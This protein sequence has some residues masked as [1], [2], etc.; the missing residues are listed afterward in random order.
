VYGVTY[1][2]SYE[3]STGNYL[4]VLNSLNG[5]TVHETI[6]PKEVAHYTGHK[7]F[8]CRVT[9]KG[10]AFA[11]CGSFNLTAVSV[12]VTAGGYR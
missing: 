3:P 12:E 4:K 8:R 10:V 7:E 6:L 9:G 5:M 2:T 11:I 1:S